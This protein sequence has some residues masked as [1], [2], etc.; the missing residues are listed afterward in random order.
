MGRAVDDHT[1]PQRFRLIPEQNLATK[2]IENM[3]GMVPVIGGA[4]EEEWRT[5]TGQETALE[6]RQVPVRTGPSL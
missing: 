2:M 3:I 1:A 4:T 5:I 6:D